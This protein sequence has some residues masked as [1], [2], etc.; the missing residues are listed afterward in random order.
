MTVRR[1]LDFL[2]AQGVLKRIHGGAV[3][4]M[5]SGLEPPYSL[6]ARAATAA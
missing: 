1:D 2:A 3:S 6:R 5:L 4:A